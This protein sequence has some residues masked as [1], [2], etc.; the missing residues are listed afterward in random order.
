MNMIYQK[1]NYINWKHEAE[2]KV[3]NNDDM[4]NKIKAI[5]AE[6][7]KAVSKTKRDEF[8]DKHYGLDRHGDYL[9]LYVFED[10][11]YVI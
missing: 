5:Q 8:D 4:V 3:L 7:T 6:R 1:I 9:S 11:K 2:I 10:G